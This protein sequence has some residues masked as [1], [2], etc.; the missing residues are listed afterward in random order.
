MTTRTAEAPAACA[1]QTFSAN[2]QG[3]EKSSPTGPRSTSIT[4][5]V[6]PPISPPVG[7]PPDDDVGERWNGG[8]ASEKGEQAKLQAGWHLL[9]WPWSGST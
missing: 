3:E 7:S 2:L 6:G 9:A 4:K 1:F 5:F 8:D